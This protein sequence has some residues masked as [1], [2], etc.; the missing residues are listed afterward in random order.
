VV[1]LPKKRWE[2][3]PGHLR[4]KRST[5]TAFPFCLLGT[6]QATRFALTTHIRSH[7]GESGL[8]IRRSR[9]GTDDPVSTGEKPYICTACQKGFKRSD[10]LTKHKQR[11]APFLAAIAAE[12][13]LE[14]AKN[15]IPVVVAGPLPPVLAAPVP[16]TTGPQTAD[17][18][19]E[20][21]ATKDKEK[22]TLQKAKYRQLKIERRILDDEYAVAVK[23]IRRLRTQNDIVLER[24][25]GKSLVDPPKS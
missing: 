25:T 24:L 17:E 10:A 16:E 1:E 2:N 3:V 15:P 20:S 23:K 7:T 22:Y 4:L 18:L 6:P 11:C 19:M 14:A 21:F 8:A 9:T 13:A 5:D 12:A